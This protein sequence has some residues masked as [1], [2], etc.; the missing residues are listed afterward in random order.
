M[1]SPTC[2]RCGNFL[3]TN[4]KSLCESCHQKRHSKVQHLP[5]LGVMTLLHGL[6]FFLIILSVALS[7]Q[8][9]SLFVPTAFFSTETLIV[10]LLTG[11]SLIVCLLQSLAWWKLRSYQGGSIATVSWVLGLTSALTCFMAP[12]SIG[13]LIWGLRVLKDPEVQHLMDNSTPKPQNL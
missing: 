1:T 13:L 2:S 5:I 6:F 11:F 3:N 4:S 12:L 8:L 9:E 10:G 7:F